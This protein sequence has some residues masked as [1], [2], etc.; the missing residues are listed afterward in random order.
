MISLHPKDDGESFFVQ[1]GVV[2][3]A[4]VNVRVSNPIGISSPLGMRWDNTA[5]SPYGDASQ[6]SIRSSKCVKTRSKRSSSLI[7]E[8]ALF[9]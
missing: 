8:N 4:L 5:P 7:H 3:S 9:C 1:M 6:A 2:F